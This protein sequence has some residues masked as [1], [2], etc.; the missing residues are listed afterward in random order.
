MRLGVDATV[1][2]AKL[3]R[4]RGR[5][6][7]AH[8]ALALSSDAAIWTRDCAFNACGLPTCTTDTLIAHLDGIDTADPR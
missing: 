3:L 7:L 5:A 8:P 6:L 4:A 2:V 1:P